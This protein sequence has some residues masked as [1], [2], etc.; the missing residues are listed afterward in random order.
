MLRLCHN[1]KLRID[2]EVLEVAYS[3]GCPLL[4]QGNNILA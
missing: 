2:R 4:T 1:A 3:G